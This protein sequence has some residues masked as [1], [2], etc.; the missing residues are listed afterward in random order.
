MEHLTLDSGHSQDKLKEI[1]NGCK[2][3]DASAV[4]ELHTILREDLIKDGMDLSPELQEPPAF[5]F[6]LAKRNSPNDKVIICIKVDNPWHF[7]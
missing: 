6:N 3:C 4:L 7:A 1:L 5:L 2:N